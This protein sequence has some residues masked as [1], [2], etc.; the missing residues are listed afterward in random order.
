MC[1][2]VNTLPV[3]TALRVWD[4]LLVEGPDVLLRVGFAVL[5]MKERVLRLADNSFNMNQ[6]LQ[7]S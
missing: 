5:Q 7:V 4:C 3:K 1:L 6:T 2:F